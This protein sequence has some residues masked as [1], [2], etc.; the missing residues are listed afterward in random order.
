L[1]PGCSERRVLNHAQH[2]RGPT[3][4]D[5]CD[6]GCSLLQAEAAELLTIAALFSL[7]FNRE[8][9][10]EA[11]RRITGRNG[12]Q[13]FA[14]LRRR[15]LIGNFAD[16]LYELQEL[17]GTLAINRAEGELKDRRYKTAACL[18]EIEPEE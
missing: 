13:A 5:R 7:P 18:V 9:L 4:D 17:V 15:A 11:Y 16:E 1:G 3:L 6:E 2:A 12:H 10:I 8:H 14:N